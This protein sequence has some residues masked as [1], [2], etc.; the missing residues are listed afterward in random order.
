MNSIVSPRR[1]EQAPALSALNAGSIATL[2]A[3][4]VLTALFLTFRP[5]ATASEAVGDGGDPVNQ[6]GYGLLGVVALLSMLMFAE[7]RALVALISPWWVLL[8]L[9]AGLSVW[10]SP[11]SSDAV[12]SFSFT[13]IGIISVCAV[14][15]LPRDIGAFTT[16]L[17]FASVVALALCYF[18]VLFMPGSAIHGAAGAEPEHAGLWRGVFSHKNIAGPV[19]AAIGFVGLFLMR[20]G[21]LA[22]GTAI[23]V[24]AFIFVWNTGSKTAAGLIPI[25]VLV[26]FLPRLF[27]LHQ[28][29]APIILTGLVVG[30]IVTVGIALFGPVARLAETMLP[31]MTYTGRLAIWE[32][33]LDMIANRPWAG[34]GYE[35]FWGIVAR[36]Q[37]DMH[38][39]MAWDVRN[40]VHAHNGYLDIALTM[41]L[42]ALLVALLVFVLAPLRDYARTPLLK[43]NVLLADLFLMMLTYTLLNALLESFFFRRADPVWIVFVLAALGLRLVARRPVP[44]RAAAEGGQ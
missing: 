36:N 2:V 42:P 24:A 16:V 12:R 39:D 15:S 13:V 20:Q 3:T 5:F 22:I 6:L 18:G 1:T 33:S 32:F 9:F 21:R 19:I 40:I 41:G 30:T 8:L 44:E 17:T 43:T 38:F 37:T 31:D 14:L 26:V 23:L 35:S 11:E 7:R 25:T 10:T 29:T 34:Y 28:L 4:L 27:G